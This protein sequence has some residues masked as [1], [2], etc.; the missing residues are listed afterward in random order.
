[1]M[2]FETQ[3]ERFATIV[4]ISPDGEDGKIDKVKAIYCTLTQIKNAVSTVLEK[5]I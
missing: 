4:P 1:M 5:K 2:E 3:A